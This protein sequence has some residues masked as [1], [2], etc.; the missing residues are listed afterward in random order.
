VKDIHNLSERQTALEIREIGKG[1]NKIGF[2]T[3]NKRGTLW[4]WIERP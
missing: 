1:F 4:Q 2:E 3:T